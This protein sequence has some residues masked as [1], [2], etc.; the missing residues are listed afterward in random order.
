MPNYEPLRFSAVPWMLDLV[1]LRPMGPAEVCYENG[2]AIAMQ[3]IIPDPFGPDSSVLL[4]IATEDW[5]Y[6]D[7]KLSIGE[8]VTEWPPPVKKRT[9]KFYPPQEDD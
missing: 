3:L 4:S 5:R 2:H 6:T 8:R 1:D 9:T 7:V